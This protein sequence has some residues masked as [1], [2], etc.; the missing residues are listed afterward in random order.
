ME[1]VLAFLDANRIWLAVFYLVG[2]CYWFYEARRARGAARRREEGGVDG[3]SL[4]V[5]KPG[6]TA[7]L[8][9]PL[10]GMTADQQTELM[11]HII[12]QTAALAERGV[13]ICLME[14]FG[15]RVIAVPGNRLSEQGQHSGDAAGDDDQLHEP[16][17]HAR[18]QA[19]CF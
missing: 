5:L 6:D 16:G 15:Q 12:A 17:V 7:L 3:E 10:R 1:H 2:V 9:L 13:G 8:L 14:D 18:Q 4:T 11:Q 19:S